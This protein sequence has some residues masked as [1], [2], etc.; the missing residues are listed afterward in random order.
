MG[1]LPILSRS[2]LKE[3]TISGFTGS[4]DELTFICVLVKKAAKRLE[5]IIV[6]PCEEIRYKAAAIARRHFLPITPRSANLIIM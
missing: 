3:V 5:Q 1:T 4:M 6:Q 2:H